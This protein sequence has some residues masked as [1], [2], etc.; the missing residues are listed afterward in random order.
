MIVQHSQTS[1]LIA[2]PHRLL[3]TSAP[4]DIMRKRRYVLV[5]I[6]ILALLSSSCQRQEARTRL[7]E[8]H[9][10]IM[11]RPAA[12]I[13][14]VIIDVSNRPVKD[15]T[16]WIYLGGQKIQTS[17]R[18]IGYDVQSGMRGDGSGE[19]ILRYLGAEGGGYE[20]SMN[21]S[22][23]PKMKAQIEAQGYRSKEIDLDDVLFATTYRI[24]DT[25]MAYQGKNIKMAVV[26]Y[27][28]V[29]EEE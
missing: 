13:H 20:V 7:D 29:L 8:G 25:E 17:D 12:E 19:V 28:V 26:K 14:L 5:T 3:A 11:P 2:H 4:H 18:L 21:A 15:A 23:P 6:L 16:V 22:G 27:T 9:K 1:S 10:W 24:G